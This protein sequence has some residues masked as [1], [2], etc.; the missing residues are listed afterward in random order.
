MRALLFAAAI[1]ASTAAITSNSPQ[2][3]G[4][5]KGI[6]L[7][8]LSWVEAEKALTPDTVVVVPLG[9]AL[10]EHGPHLKLRNDLALAEYFTDRIVTAAPVV[11]TAPLTYHFYPAFLD[12]PGS[13]S[14]S[15]ETARDAT[16][17]IVR[18]LAQ[19][20]P[21][22]FYVLNT[23]ISTV[24]AL[25]PAAAALASEGILLRF[26]DLG[27]AMDRIAAPVRRQE[28]GSHADEIETSMMLYI[29]PAS[30]DMT[31][32][33]KDVAP[34]SN[35]MRLRRSSG[36][37]GTY[38]PSGVWGD[39]TLATRDKGQVVVEGLVSTML[40][41]IEGLRRAPLPVPGMPNS[42]PTPAPAAPRPVESSGPVQPNGCTPGDERTIRRVELS[43]NF[44]W[45]Q[46]DAEGVAALWTEEGDIVHGDGY[47]E[48]GRRTIQQNRAEQFRRKEYR[49]SR[50]TLAFGS[51]RCITRSVGVVDAKWEL[52]DVLDTAGNTLPN[53]EGLS[54]LV[55][56]R[57]G[58]AWLIEAYRYNVKPGTASPP[59][60]L[61]RPG[62]PDKR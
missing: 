51:V 53:A 30:V 49:G 12:Y 48:R 28:D 45:R 27:G 50:H 7:E 23:G 16:V 9:A 3:S 1:V 52:R 36:L 29:D 26:T 22:R 55:V 4:S 40:A 60:F 54:T 42:A 11:A 2:L 15:L 13:T 61:T 59:R 31:R 46:M 35:P 14:L 43:F 38:S 47:T 17:Q 57:A 8:H 56:R 25:E 33:V 34:R 20:G 10:K 6:R 44:A 39:A 18:S 21:R 41:D 5:P 58:E 19:H 62:Y 37:P 32:A 24:R